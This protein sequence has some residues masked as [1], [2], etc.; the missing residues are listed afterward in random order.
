MEQDVYMCKKRMSCKYTILKNRCCHKCWLYEKC[1]TLNCSGWKI[2]QCL[3]Q[4]NVQEYSE[5]QKI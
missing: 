2:K 3:S 4:G 1:P 5:E